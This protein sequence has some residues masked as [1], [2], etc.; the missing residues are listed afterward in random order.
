MIIDRRRFLAVAAGGYVASAAFPKLSLAAN[1]AGV[2]R[3]GLSAFG[4]L[5]YPEGFAA[6]DYANPDAPVG[7]TF[8]F[9]PWYWYFNQNTQTFNTLNAFVRRGDAPPRMELCFDTLMVSAHDEPDAIYGHVAETVTISDDGDRFT[10]RLRDIARFHDGTPI[11]AADVRFSYDTLKADGHP[12]LSLPLDPLVE[13]IEEDE[14]TVTLV[15]DGT[16][17]AQAILSVA[18]NYPIFSAAYYADRTF[19]ESTLDA[20]LGSGPYRVGDLN[21]GSFIEFQRVEDYWA[22]AI[23]TGAGQNHFGAIRIEFYAERQAGFEAFKKGEVHWRR[24]FTSKTWATEYN[25]PA[26]EQDQVLTGEFPADVRPGMQA[27]TLNQRRERFGDRRVRDAIGLCFDFEWTNENLFYGLYERSHSLF[28][29]SQ[30][31]AKGAPDAA[32]TALIERLG[33]EHDLPEGIM[34]EAWLQPAS[35]GS[36]RDRARLREATRLLGEAGWTDDGAGLLRNAAG[37]TL[38]VEFLIRS[39]VFERIYGPF[40]E[41][42]RMVGI[43]AGLRLVDPAQYQARTSEFDFDMAGL[44][45]GWTPTPTESSIEGVF[46]SAAADLPGSRNWPGV[47]DPLIDALIAEVGAAESRAG[48]ETAMRVLD[49]VLRL[50]RDWIPNWRSANQFIAH[51]DMFGF[52]PK[53]DYFWPVEALWW[54]DEDRAKAIGRA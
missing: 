8:N 20:P 12:Q 36:G 50:R 13:V 46:G 32:E 47:A 34:E 42:M 2:P 15:F 41:V 14:R 48:H 37:E 28:A 11:T 39:S 3:H 1:P 33:A 38:D 54:F 35:D 22:R 7:G 26:I 21:A 24:E 31:E 53:P 10:F 51:W 5:K 25:F 16:Q 27:W 19:D 29:G 44:A 18:A 30:Y 52:D 40:V 49:R 23:G 4:D 9:Q 17:S 45:I 43:N 6:F